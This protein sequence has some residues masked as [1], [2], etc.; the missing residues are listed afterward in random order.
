[1]KVNIAYNILCAVSLGLVKLSI[2]FFFLKI[3]NTCSSRYKRVLWATIVFIACFTSSFVFAQ[4]FICIPPSC[5]WENSGEPWQG[6]KCHDFWEGEGVYP[7]INAALDV[8]WPDPLDLQLWY[9]LESI[10]AFTVACVPFIRLMMVRKIIPFVKASFASLC[11]PVEQRNTSQRTIIRPP[12]TRDRNLDETSSFSETNMPQITDAGGLIF[13]REGSQLGVP[14]QNEGSPSDK[15]NSS[16]VTELNTKG[17]DNRTLTVSV[18]NPTA[19]RRYGFVSRA[20]TVTTNP[21]AEGEENSGWEKQ[22]QQDD[23][24]SM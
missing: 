7:A 15:V 2:S 21:I 13:P 10:T 14:L 3:F 17:Q 20:V 19:L 16:N 23:R 8:W 18:P 22:P 11:L 4:L 12:P 9:A 6:C 24:W 5:L 1:M